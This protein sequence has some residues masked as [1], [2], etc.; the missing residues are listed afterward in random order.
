MHNISVPRPVMPE[1]PAEI[2]IT[3]AIGAAIIVQSALALL[4]AG[5]A[6]ERLAQLEKRAGDTAEIIERTAR[7]EE[8]SRF[9][10]QA[11]ERIEAKLDR[12]GGEGGQ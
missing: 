6:T 7:L 12:V 4:W 2:R 3:L 9:M 10:T 5:A 8:Q 1:K 11:L